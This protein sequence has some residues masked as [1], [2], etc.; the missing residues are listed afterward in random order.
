MSMDICK[1]CTGPEKQD[2]QTRISYFKIV[3]LRTSSIH[4]SKNMYQA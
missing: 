4:Q 1:M 2:N 3:T